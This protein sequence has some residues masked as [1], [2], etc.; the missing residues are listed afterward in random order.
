ME[1]IIVRSVDMPAG[2]RGFTVLDYAGDYNVYINTR[3]SYE[4]Q[5]SALEH[6]INHIKLGHFNSSKSIDD[7]E[8]EANQPRH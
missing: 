8:F 4:I 1:E 2:V 6:E 5:K 3:Q 7:I